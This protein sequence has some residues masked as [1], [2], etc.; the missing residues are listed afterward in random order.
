[1]AV[2][3]NENIMLNLFVNYS[4]ELADCYFYVFFNINYRL[5]FTLLRQSERDNETGKVGLL[6]NNELIL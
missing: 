2:P 5:F 6:K 1:M 3:A 4:S